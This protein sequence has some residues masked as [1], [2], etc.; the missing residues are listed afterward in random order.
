MFKPFTFVPSCHPI[1]STCLS[2]PEPICPA[3]CVSLLKIISILC[4]CSLLVDISKTRAP[5]KSFL[6]THHLHLAK[7][8]DLIQQPKINHG[9]SAMTILSI[10]L[11][12]IECSAS[13][14]MRQI[15]EPFACLMISI[16]SSPVLDGKS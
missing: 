16:R 7:W 8:Q 9:N 6:P 15:T 2:I 1:T 13:S 12:A 5:C 10:P 4:G 3:S 11:K 14:T